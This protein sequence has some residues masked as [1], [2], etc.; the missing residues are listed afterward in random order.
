MKRN[1]GKDLENR[2]A[3]IAQIYEA[4]GVAVLRKCDPPSRTFN[5]NGK[6]ITTLLKNPYPDFV[7]VWAE[8]GGR[9]LMI[10]AKST[11]EPRLPIMG[12]SGGVKKEQVDS[13]MLWES[14]GAAVGVVWEYDLHWRFVSLE[15]I[16]KIANEKRGKN[17]RKSIRWEEAQA[18]QQNGMNYMD[19]LEII[20]EIYK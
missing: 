8:R 4:Q 13:L 1:T 12:K 3:K 6:N 10:E 19:F 9:T 15:L 14:F 5:I 2:I 11:K 16:N 7:G 20:S 18:I 17:Y